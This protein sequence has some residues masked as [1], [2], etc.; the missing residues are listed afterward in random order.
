MCNIY[1]ISTHLILFKQFNILNHIMTEKLYQ[2][3]GKT[4]CDYKLYK[5]ININDNSIMKKISKN[6]GMNDKKPI[7]YSNYF[8]I[9]GFISRSRNY[10]KI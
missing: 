8:I 3:K 9:I 4:I 5:K 1:D 2:E 10:K 7:F 6:L